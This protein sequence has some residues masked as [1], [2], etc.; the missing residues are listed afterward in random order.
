LSVRTSDGETPDRQMSDAGDDTSADESRRRIR[1]TLHG[2]HLP[3]LEEEGLI[4]YDRET[5]QIE[6]GPQF[7]QIRRLLERQEE[8]DD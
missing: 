7:H 5:G 3:M 8:F 6:R 2:T 4:T 1:E